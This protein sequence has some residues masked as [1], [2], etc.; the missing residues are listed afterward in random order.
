MISSNTSLYN[1]RKCKPHFRAI[2]IVLCK[3]HRRQ[4]SS[5]HCRQAEYGSHLYTFTKI[6]F[7]T[8][9]PRVLKIYDFV[10]HSTFPWLIIQTVSKNK[11]ISKN[12]Y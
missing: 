12:A 5:Q 10:T 2:F 9:L 4:F 6:D 8:L 1:A 3:L 11:L 7:S